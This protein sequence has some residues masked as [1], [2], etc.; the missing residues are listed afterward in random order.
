MELQSIKW[1][2]QWETKSDSKQVFSAVQAFLHVNKEPKNQKNKMKYDETHITGC[3][4]QVGNLVCYQTIHLS[5]IIFF[6]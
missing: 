3:I 1:N 4:Q 6:P 2:Q 5:L